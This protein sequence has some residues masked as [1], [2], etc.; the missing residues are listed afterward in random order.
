MLLQKPIQGGDFHDLV[1]PRLPTVD[2]QAHPPFFPPLAG[3]LPLRDFGDRICNY[4]V[5]RK[6]FFL[7][8]YLSNCNCNRQG[9]LQND[10][11]SVTSIRIHNAMGKI[12]CKAVAKF[13]RLQNNLQPKI[14]LQILG[15][16]KPI[17]M[18][19]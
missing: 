1:V 19:L 14:R 13:K 10:H 7:I 17:A 16:C 11:K 12:N 2:H 18:G 5:S 8:F 15:I 4:K 3:V 9:W 6:L